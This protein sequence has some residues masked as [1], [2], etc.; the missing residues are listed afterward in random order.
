M[1]GVVYRPPSRSLV[2]FFRQ[3]EILLDSLSSLSIPVVTQG[4]FNIDLLKSG[5]ASVNEFVDLLPMRGFSNKITLPSRVNASS[6]LWL[7]FV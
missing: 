7:I 4:D 2:E 3:F 1:T 5:N 6:E